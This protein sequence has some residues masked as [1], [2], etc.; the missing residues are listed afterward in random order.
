MCPSGVVTT[1]IA[2]ARTSQPALAMEVAAAVDGA[3]GA[4]PSQ[5]AAAGVGSN[6]RTIDAAVRGADGPT[7][8]TITFELKVRRA[9]TAA[10]LQQNQ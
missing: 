6:A 5:I 8:Q 3:V 1:A 9:D 7:A 10:M 2:S 4:S